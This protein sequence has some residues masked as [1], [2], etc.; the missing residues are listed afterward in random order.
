[1]CVCVYAYV[2]V[3][4]LS[5]L[6]VRVCMHGRNPSRTENPDD[7]QACLTFLFFRKDGTHIHMHAHTCA[8]TH[9][10]AQHTY[11]HA[12]THIR[13][14]A[15]LHA[16]THPPTYH[17]RSSGHGRRWGSKGCRGLPFGAGKM[18]SFLPMLLPGPQALLACGRP[19]AQQIQCTFL[20]TC[21]CICNKGGRP[22]PQ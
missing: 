6:C 2:H 9:A 22:T 18:Q 5:R 10:W 11:M 14:H 17:Q 15:N 1:M 19:A 8:Y 20:N 3:H 4:V 16:E 12:S 13:A 7:W 21:V